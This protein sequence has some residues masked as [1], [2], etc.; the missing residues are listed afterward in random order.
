[1][2]RTRINCE[3]QRV[4]TYYKALRPDGTDFA[5]GKT[6]PV[7]GEWMPKMEG[8]LSICEHGYHVADAAAETLVGG[9][10]PCKLY[11]VEAKVLD[12]SQ[13]FKGDHLHKGVCRTYRLVE[14][15]P[16]WQVFG[17]NGE[18]VVALVEQARTLTPEDATRLAAAWDA[19]W[20]AARD[21]AWHAAR[22]AAWCAARDAAWCA[23]RDAAW[24]AARYAAWCAAR[25]AAGYAAR[26]AAWD[27]ARD[28]AWDAAGSA[29]GSAAG[30][31]VARDLITTKQFDILYGPWR[32]VMETPR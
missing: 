1:M 17:P 8:L 31:L 5:T 15:L 29:A 4:R 23:A 2:A 22:Y 10:W 9:S 32:A 28:A 12:R 19:A 13:S 3:G 16:S 27:A 11:R 24:H 7:L 6:R 25:D 21:A 30:A 14:E 20:Y 26:D 18:A